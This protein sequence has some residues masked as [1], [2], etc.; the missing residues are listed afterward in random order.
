MS[1]NDP[2]ADM[3]TRIR[4]AQN[5]GEQQVKMPSSNFK[6]AILN[7]LK[8]EG[9]IEDYQAQS[10]DG[11]SDI[12]VTLKYHNGKPVIGKI[13]RISKA[14]LRIYKR[15]NALP[16]VLAGMGIAIISTPKGV[17]TE[18]SARAQKLGGEVL[19]TVE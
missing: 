5:V 13:K 6:I 14:G 3:L 17:M 16:V 4:N 9:Y 10:T 8:E 18:R 12:T 2:I 11:K 7:V 19:C 1:M 15:T